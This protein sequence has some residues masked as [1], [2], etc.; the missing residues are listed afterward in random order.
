MQVQE[1][2]QIRRQKGMEIAKKCR[3][4]EKNG[5]WLVPSATQPH[6]VYQVVLSL[7]GNTC[8]CEDFVNRRLRCKHIFAVEITVSKTLNKDGTTTITTTK[9]VTYPQ[10]WHAYDLASTQQK[11]LYLKLLSDLCNTIEEPAYEFGRPKLPLKDM[12]FG[13][14]LKVYSTFSLR[15]FTTDM[16]EAQSKGYV[17]K[18]P[19]YSTIA[20]YMESADLTPI[21]RNLIA[22]SAMPLKAIETDFSIDSTGFSSSRF[23]KW[24]DHKWGQDKDVR[25]WL[26][27]HLVNGN[28]THIVTAVEVTDSNVN[29][30]T[31]LPQLVTETHE[32]FNVATLDADKAY[33][34]RNN[35]D[36]LNALG[37]TPY[38]PF[39]ENAT[40][41][42]HGHT[43]LWKKMYNYFTFN[44][45]Q[46]LTFYHNRSNAETVPHMIKS[47]FGDA[48][49]S[50]TETAQVN[51]VLLKVLC[52]NICVLISE[53]FELGI[54]ASFVA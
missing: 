14:A 5:I 47:K 22:V 34:S 35:Y 26:K 54:E 13:S 25:V 49:R 15:R 28:S 30:T 19:Y 33:S 41:K 6:K 50:K 21:L 52:H 48:V 39:K 7:R 44:R 31:M 12:V 36:C 23:A 43:L 51:E 4:S 46:F 42:P 16:K 3:V 38:I 10:C 32:T 2:L 37:I 20:R 53:M 8:T 1:M 18:A 9:K 17:K 11:E 45:E 24:F 27:A 40:G 29:D